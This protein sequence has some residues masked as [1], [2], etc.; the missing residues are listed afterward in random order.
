MDRRAAGLSEESVWAHEYL[1]NSWIM[2]GSERAHL[3]ESAHIHRHTLSYAMLQTIVT[4]PQVTNCSQN[5][6]IYTQMM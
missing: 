5:I 1:I 3:G 2:Q 6:H 4:S